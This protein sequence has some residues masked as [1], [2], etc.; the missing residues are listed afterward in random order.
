MAN[1]TTDK[2]D[3]A[4]AEGGAYEVIR[5]RLLT[6]S[7][8]TDIAEVH[9]EIRPA[10]EAVWLPLS[11][12]DADAPYDFSLNMTELSLA[13]GDYVVRA[14]ATD[15]LGNVGAA[16]TGAITLDERPPTVD[17]LGMDN[18]LAVI[19][20]THVFSGVISEQPAWGGALATYHFAS[21]APFADNS[22]NG[23]DAT[24][25]AC[26]TGT[27][28]IFGRSLHAQSSLQTGRSVRCLFRPREFAPHPG[29]F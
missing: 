11:P 26:P 20:Q 7:D 1:G 22:G 25:T 18:A 3:V 15:A 5:K 29:G 16:T 14:T 23:N 24:C 27:A 6:Q 21:N 4:V 8:D 10:T 13:Y 17:A 12:S 28:G 9:F 2:V 19:S